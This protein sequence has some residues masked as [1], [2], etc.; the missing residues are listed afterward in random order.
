MLKG[1]PKKKEVRNPRGPNRPCLAGEPS[2]GWGGVGKRRHRK[3]LG[4][5]WGKR[6][7]IVLKDQD[8]L[9]KYEKLRLNHLTWR[10]DGLTTECSISR[11]GQGETYRWDPSIWVWKP[12]GFLYVF[13]LIDITDVHRMI[14][15]IK[16]SWPQMWRLNTKN[17][18]YQWI[19]PIDHWL[20]AS[21]LVFQ[22][23]SQFSHFTNSRLFQ[24]Y[25]A[26]WLPAEGGDSPWF[27]GFAGGCWWWTSPKINGSVQGKNTYRNP[28][29]FSMEYA[30]ERNPEWHHP[31]LQ[32]VL[33]PD[34]I[35][36]LVS[37]SIYGGFLK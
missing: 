18:E 23:C 4:V 26:E 9:S 27:A 25:F 37:S 28:C 21:I 36:L 13:T 33:A 20:A 1:M 14:M 6:S 15:F 31:I 12:A 22:S 24:Q 35:A 10:F 19:Q 32:V 8:V 2:G 5:S 3:V 30:T 16:L 29:F 17:R 11:L 7:S 34:L